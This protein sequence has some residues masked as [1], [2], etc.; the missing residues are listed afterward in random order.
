MDGSQDTGIPVRRDNG[1]SFTT[2]MTQR[3]FNSGLRLVGGWVGKDDTRILVD[4]NESVLF[5]IGA[6]ISGLKVI[7]SNSG[8][9]PSGGFNHLCLLVCLR[10]V[11]ESSVRVGPQFGLAANV[12]GGVRGLMR[13]QVLK[14]NADGAS[15]NLGFCARF[16][17]FRL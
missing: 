13:Q 5:T 2:K 16:W 17:C 11:F 7:A 14:G 8:E 12:A 3:D 6:Y 4:A 9:E 1:T 15:E 10:L